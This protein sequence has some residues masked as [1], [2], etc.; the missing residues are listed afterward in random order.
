MKKKGLFLDDQH[1]SLIS[2]N[3]LVLLLGKIKLSKL[4]I[5]LIFSDFCYIANWNSDRMKL[6]PASAYV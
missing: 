1:F 6:L 5:Y 3:F 4:L 2:D